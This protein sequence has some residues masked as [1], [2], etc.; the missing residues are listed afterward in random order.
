LD[1]VFKRGREVRGLYHLSRAVNVGILKIPEEQCHLHTV[2]VQHE[3]I[4]DI[5]NAEDESLLQRFSQTIM[6]KNN[7]KKLNIVFDCKLIATC[8]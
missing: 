5:H 8:Y 6:Q 1:D 7:N 2:I 3:N 4:I